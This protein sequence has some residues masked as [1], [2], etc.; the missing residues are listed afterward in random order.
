MIG[1]WVAALVVAAPPIE[2]DLKPVCSSITLSEVRDVLSVEM[3]AR[4]PEPS[5]RFVTHV[6]VACEG[7]TITV[8]V[9]DPISRKELERK[10][11]FS[12]VNPVVRSR[13]L[14]LAV[15]ELVALSWSE[16]L[17]NPES[18]AEPAGPPPPPEQ[19]DEAAAAAAA[20][21]R[22]PRLRSGRV[23]LEGTFQ[24]FQGG[25]QLWGVAGR[26]SWERH[27]VFGLEIDLRVEH[28]ALSLPQGTVFANRASLGMA[29]H[30]R[31]AVGPVTFRGFAG[32]RGGA[33]RLMGM[34]ATVGSA[35]EGSGVGPWLGAML[36]G[37]GAIAL[38]PCSFELGLHAGIPLVGVVGIVDGARAAAMNG[39]SFGLHVG[40]GVFP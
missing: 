30:A 18:V 33:V 39:F 38:G 13:A 4:V 26:Y 14:A 5:S 8:R 6:R 29:G 16:L 22:V 32:L 27:S 25:L 3:R 2:V 12:M 19:R 37:A 34:A 17:A 10:Y 35:R 31:V 24:V 40:V 20:R 15:V 7:T 1:T 9:E 23:L 21:A 11:D 28:G 36:G